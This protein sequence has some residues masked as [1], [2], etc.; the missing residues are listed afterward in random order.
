MRLDRSL[1]SGALPVKRVITI[2]LRPV[3]A[4]QVGRKEDYCRTIRDEY[5][6]KYLGALGVEPSDRNRAAV[7]REAPLRR[8]RFEANWDNRH[9]A[10]AA[11]LDILLPVPGAS[12]KAAARLGPGGD[13]PGSGP[14]SLAWRGMT[15]FMDVA[16]PECAPGPVRGAGVVD[17]ADAPGRGDA[18]GPALPEAWRRG[19]E[20]AD[21]DPGLTAELEAVRERA[22]QGED[23]VE[24]VGDDELRRLEHL[25]AMERELAALKRRFILP[26]ACERPASRG[27]VEI[28]PWQSA[29]LRGE[30]CLELPKDHRDEALSPISL[31]IEAIQ[32]ELK[33]YADHGLPLPLLTHRPEIAGCGAV[34]RVLAS[35]RAARLVGLLA[36]LTYWTVLGHLHPQERRL[37]EPSKQSLVLTLQEVWATLRRPLTESPAGVSFVLPA[38]LLAVKRGVGRA[39]EVQYPKALADLAVA[40]QLAFFINI[41]VM[42]LF[43]PDC[44]YA[45]FAATSSDPGA[46]RLERRLGVVEAARGLGA[47]RRVASRLNRATPVVHS[48]L[49]EEFGCRPGDART[50]AM[51]Q[52]SASDSAM[53]GPAGVSGGRKPPPPRARDAME[54]VRRATL[55]RV[56]LGR[57]EHL[58]AARKQASST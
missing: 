4:G 33:E 3:K 29:E 56:A 16:P 45:R 12:G 41:I 6:R 50:R 11:S 42:R 48:L 39:F 43:D 5:V 25:E 46:I 27:K 47:S 19:G 15:T 40:S 26:F 9:S 20:A 24:S 38:V 13:P 1:S 49:G 57:L 7:A 44:T 55:V 2:P 14:E 37:P 34:R 51:L 10:V 52:K 17:A 58:A 35:E 54:D 32:A 8:C 30:L 31:T 28:V 18:R 53:H 36:H 21:A 22:R 23:A